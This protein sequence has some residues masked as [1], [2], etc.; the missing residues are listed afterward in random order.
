MA[1]TTPCHGW[2]DTG[3]LRAA[4]ECVALSPL[5]SCWFPVGP[6]VSA[7]HRERGSPLSQRLVFQ[8]RE[9]G[10]RSWLQPKGSS[11][12]I[13]PEP[14]E[15]RV[16]SSVHTAPPSGE[17]RSRELPQAWGCHCH[18]KYSPN[19]KELYVLSVALIFIYL[20]SIHSFSCLR[21]AL[22]YH[23]LAS[24]LELQPKMTDI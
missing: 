1:R 19:P 10:L 18:H 13:Y 12:A 5:G 23:R 4:Q 20:S 2:F 14:P 17:E 8:G 3:H 6:V 24:E 22:I 21:Q 11:A 7:V 16:V 15:P 9:R